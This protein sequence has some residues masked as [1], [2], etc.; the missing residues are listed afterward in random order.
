MEAAMRTTV[1]LNESVLRN[2]KRYANSHGITLTSL[3]EQSLRERLSRS[4]CAQSGRPVNL[5]TFRGNGVRPGV[6]IDDTAALLDA[7]EGR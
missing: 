3:V 1:R 4:T 2:A 7:V 6:D 5:P